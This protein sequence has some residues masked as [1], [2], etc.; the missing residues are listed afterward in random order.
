MKF[1]ESVSVV[2]SKALGGDLNGNWV[3]G[4]TDGFGDMDIGVVWMVTGT[5]FEFGGAGFWLQ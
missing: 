3:G 4:Q 1:F 2:A 5:R